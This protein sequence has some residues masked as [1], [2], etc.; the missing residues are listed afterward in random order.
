MSQGFGFGRRGDYLDGH[1]W[2]GGVGML[3]DGAGDDTY[4]CG[5]FGQGGGYW[6]GVGILADKGGDD[7]YL[8]PVVLPGRRRRTSRWASCRTG[9]NDTYIGKMNMCGGA[10]HDF[11]LGWLEDRGGQRQPT[12]CRTLA[13]AAATPTG[14][15]VLGPRGGRQLPHQRRHAGQASVAGL[16]QRARFHHD[17][18]RV[19]RR[20]RG[21]SLFRA[22][23]GRPGLYTIRLLRR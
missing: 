20:R 17:A 8:G 5:I 1:S 7:S 6:Y 22:P 23:V 11:S 4:T 18:G 3:V 14:G 9:G 21:G 16:G 15:R 10:G 19:R 13:W 12:T 2:A